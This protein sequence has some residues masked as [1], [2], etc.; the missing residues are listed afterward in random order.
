ML[1]SWSKT[2]KIMTVFMFLTDK[3]DLHSQI[4]DKV[5][6]ETDQRLHLPTMLDLNKQRVRFLNVINIILSILNKDHLTHNQCHQTCLNIINGSMKK[7]VTKINLQLVVRVKDLQDLPMYAKCTICTN[8]PHQSPYHVGRKEP[9]SIVRSRA[10]SNTMTPRYVTL[11]RPE[12]QL[13][14]YFTCS[15]LITQS[16]K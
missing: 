16:K 9:N 11:P 6:I 15:S 12:F 14:Y 7:P 1:P 5:V 2:V 10:S 4:T 8:S 3:G 13:Q